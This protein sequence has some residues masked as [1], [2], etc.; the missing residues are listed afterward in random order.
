MAKCGDR[1]AYLRER[2][3][4]TQEELANKLGISRA[5]LSHYETNRRDPDYGTLGK[6]A[7]FFNI[8]LDYLL[9]RTN[10]PE[11][12]LE[13]DVR[14]FVDSL[15]L[16]DDNILDKFT[17]TIDGR[18]LTPEESKRFIAFVRAERSMKQ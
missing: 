10:N 4:L 14:D 16:A 3:G 11:T 6:I 18:K 13:S 8:S 9:G 7:T 2:R 1:I 15:E 12:I 5:S 17:L